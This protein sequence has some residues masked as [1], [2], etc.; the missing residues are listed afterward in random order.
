[1]VAKGIVNLYAVQGSAFC[2][3]AFCIFI[4]TVSVDEINR[5]CD[6]HAARNQPKLSEF[7]LLAIHGSSHTEGFETEDRNP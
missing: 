3:Q 1:M 6:I 7:W 5:T 4:L 2:L